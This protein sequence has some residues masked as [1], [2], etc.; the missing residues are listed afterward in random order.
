[1]AQAKKKSKAPPSSK[2]LTPVTVANPVGRPTMYR[3]EYCQMLIDHMKNGQS[4]ETFG[5]KIGASWRTCYLWAD[6]HEEFLQAK[7]IGKT[8]LLDVYEQAGRNLALGLVPPPPVDENGRPTA[9]VTR[10]N[11]RMAMFMMAVH[12]PKIYGAFLQKAPEEEAA[13]EARIVFEYTDDKQKPS[14]EGEA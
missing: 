12:G 5:A 4:F 1:M 10:G 3:P 2:A 6:T 14:G 11:A 13:G 7:E 9:M 8:F